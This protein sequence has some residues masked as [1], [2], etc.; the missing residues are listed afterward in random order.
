MQIKKIVPEM[1]VEEQ[2]RRRLFQEKHK[3]TDKFSELDL[4]PGL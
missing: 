3:I 1:F 2:R 4:Q